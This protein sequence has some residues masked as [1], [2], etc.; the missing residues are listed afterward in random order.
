VAAINSNIDVDILKEPEKEKNARDPFLFP[1]FF[2]LSFKGEEESE[3]YDSISMGGWGDRKMS[4][5]VYRCIKERVQKSIPETTTTTTVTVNPESQ[6]TTRVSTSSTKRIECITSLYKPIFVDS[7]TLDLSIFEE[8]EDIIKGLNS[9]KKDEGDTTTTTAHTSNVERE[10]I[11]QIL[12]LMQSNNIDITSNDTT[13]TTSEQGGTITQNCCVEGC[14]HTSVYSLNKGSNNSISDINRYCKQHY[15]KVYNSMRSQKECT[16]EGCSGK[17]RRMNMC[18]KHYTGHKKYGTRCS[19]CT[20]IAY[21]NGMCRTH[22]SKSVTV[23]SYPKC[24]NTNIVS[25]K[26]ALCK[27]HYSRIARKNQQQHNDSKNSNRKMEVV[28]TEKNLF[29]QCLETTPCLMKEE[30]NNEEYHIEL[31]SEYQD[32]DMINSDTIFSF[33]IP[34][35]TR[36]E[37]GS[38]EI[39]LPSEIALLYNRTDPSTTSL[40]SP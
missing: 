11:Q 6:V 32:Y 40:P 23:C 26:Y 30:K 39:L 19:V 1:S 13:S 20:E 7:N 25:K 31:P 22:Y 29:H 14:P 21:M 16:I 2:I 9:N 38:D 5:V 35:P 18:Y 28:S 3:K 15:N 17:V 10:F 27:R 37:D 8:N 33:I 36:E 34:P 4:T 24:E 12:D